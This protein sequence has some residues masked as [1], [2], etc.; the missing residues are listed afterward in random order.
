MRNYKLKL[1]IIHSSWEQKANP[2]LA[3][4]FSPAF[5][6]LMRK[7]LWQPSSTY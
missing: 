4:D 3:D 1:E 5:S 7:E 6:H 2:S